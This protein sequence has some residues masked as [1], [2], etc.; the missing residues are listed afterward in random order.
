MSQDNDAGRLPGW[1]L[2]LSL[3]GG[4]AALAILWGCRD[5]GLSWWIG[6]P[7]AI[8]VVVG[9]VFLERAIEGKYLPAR[10]SN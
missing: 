8:V 7:A 2:L 5:A 4:F 9:V 6:V 3:A 1:I 10:R